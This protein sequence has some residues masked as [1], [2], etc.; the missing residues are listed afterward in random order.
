MAFLAQNVGLWFGRVELLARGADEHRREAERWLER[1]NPLQARMH[2]LMLLDRVPESPIGLALLVDA[3]EAAGLDDE[4]VEVLRRL[5]DAAPW[6]GELWVRLGQALAR[7]GAPAPERAAAFQRALDPS[8]EP[9][10]RREALLEL[11]DLDLAMGDPWRARRWLDGLRLAS[12]EPEVELRQLEASLSLGDRQGVEKAL[13]AVREPGVID[14][15]ATL[16]RARGEAML[17][18][19]GA[20]DG[21]L[22]AWILE[23]PGATEAL[24]SYVA[25][26]RD[27]VHVA[28]VRDVLRADGREQEPTFALALALAEGRSEDA[29]QAL[30]RI[31]RSGDRGAARTLLGIAFERR[32]GEALRAAL[33]VLGEEA[34]REAAC[35]GRLL[36]AAEQER[37][38]DVETEGD[39]LAGAEGAVRG[40]AGAARADAWRVRLE[41]GA[42]GL[43]DALTAVRRVAVAWDRLDLVSRCEALSI[44]R[45]RPLRLAVVGE[46]NAG[47]ST[48]INALIGADVAPTGV[49]PTTATLHWL[50]WAPD[51]FARIAVRGGPDRVVG[52]AALKDALREIQAGGG[53]AR[54]VHICAPMERLKRMEVLDTPG[55]NALDPD[56]LAAAR[57]AVEEAHVMLWVFDASQPLKETERAVL[58][59][60]AASGVPIQAVINKRD[61]VEDREV[62]SIVDHVEEGLRGLGLEQVGPV[63]ALSARAA[64]AGRMGDAESYARSGWERVEQALSSGIAD[65]SDAMR[66]TAVRRK[67]L[68]IVRELRESAPLVEL[69]RQGTDVG[70]RLE[71]LERSEYEQIVARLEEPLRLLAEDLKPLRVASMPP[72]EPQA[73]A[74]AEARR[75]A[76]IAGPL[77]HLLA[78]EASLGP[79]EA[80]LVGE[81]VELVVRGGAAVD[82]YGGVGW[83][84]VQACARAGHDALKRAGQERAEAGHDAARGERL[85]VLGE[86]LGTGLQVTSGS[87]RVAG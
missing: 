58:A 77:T 56:H 7:T 73:R 16:A 27:A 64:L 76:R 10:S 65:R 51:P 71:E 12:A 86:A 78:Q 21:L 46:F 8:V 22:R 54:E 63:L 13:G 60:I 28:R 79:R 67:A 53:V 26:C 9:S 44:E 3:T 20:L 72:D 48:F 59:E 82:P 17:G 57:R 81:A 18:G 37:W 45:E 23:A 87:G 47:K 35:M 19:E 61:R 83:P 15:R 49:L 40:W 31:A 4:C 43:S 14:G 80:T 38:G 69:G 75:V 29:R 33:E 74:Y 24:A 5:C 70:R 50:S 66:A 34:P 85:R 6:R 42:Q 41:R 32:D 68:G 62:P 1:G 36:R 52:H 2:A 30:T 25:A 39:L 55:F 84:L 11:A